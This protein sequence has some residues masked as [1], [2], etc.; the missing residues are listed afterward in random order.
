MKILTAVN[1]IKII[2]FISVVLFIVTGMSAFIKIINIPAP[3]HINDAEALG[4]F[5]SSVAQL[6][7]YIFIELSLMPVLIILVSSTSKKY[8][9]GA[10]INRS[11]KDEIISEQRKEL[12]KQNKLINN[13]SNLY[14]DAIEYDRLKTEFFSNI[15]HELK[16]PLSVILGAIQLIDH[17]ASFTTSEQ[18]H[19]VKHL[20]IIKQNCYRLVRLINNI[21]DITRID[22]GYVKTNMVN[23]NIIYLL[24]EITQSVAPYAEQKG[25]SIEFDTEIEELITAV[26]ID[27]IERIALN[28]LSNAIKFTCPEGKVSVNVSSRN[29]KVFI[30]VKDTGLGI[31]RKM[32][33][34]IFERFKQVNSSLTREHEGSGIGLSLVKSFVE[35]HNGNIKVNSE[36]NK[37]SEFIIEM[38]ISI[39]D[40]TAEDN[41]NMHGRQNKIIEAINIEFSDIYSFAS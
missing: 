40:S 23:C 37:G 33:E 8:L 36:E 3:I 5:N 9:N 38:P 11:E 39:R 18:K 25:L 4:A 10:I 2:I 34:M 29:D 31:P 22:S 27:K 6:K 17:K 15:S 32:H 20:K 16:T 41:L 35:L 21:L 13:L 19:S 28:L 7:Y 14:N 26:D 30:T 1:L 24:E 12:E